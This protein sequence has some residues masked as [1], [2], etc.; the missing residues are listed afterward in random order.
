MLPFIVTN[1]DI[2]SFVS[3]HQSQLPHQQKQRTDKH[4]QKGM[5][6]KK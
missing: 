5:Y 4:I 1:A 6:E 2:H 3:L